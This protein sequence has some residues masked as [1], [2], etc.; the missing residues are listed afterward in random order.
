MHW[1]KELSWE[2]RPKIR[3]WGLEVNSNLT[4]VQARVLPPPT[5]MYS[6][7][8]GRSQPRNGSWNLLGKQFFKPGAPLKAWSVVSFDQHADIKVMQGF[9]TYLVNNLKR[10][11]MSVPTERPPLIGP[12][13][14]AQGPPGPGGVSQAVLSALTEAGSA[15]FAA[16]GRTVAPQLILVILPGR[17][18]LLYEEVKRCAA[19]NLKAPV[20]TQCMLAMKLRSERGLDQYSNSEY[21]SS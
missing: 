18:P 7:N 19:V 10:N 21:L 3:D 2:T 5:V 17:D 6:G 13:N 9:I 4:E 12:I 1:R 14:P 8:N 11:G 15:A 20:P 16:G